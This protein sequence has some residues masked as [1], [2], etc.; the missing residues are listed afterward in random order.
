M[1]FFD[2]L[3]RDYFGDGMPISEREPDPIHPSERWVAFAGAVFL[4]SAATYMILMVTRDRAY[5]EDWKTRVFERCVI[6]TNNFTWCWLHLG[7][8]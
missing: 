4:I 6:E 2:R 3:R 5:L 7:P 8:I 1:P